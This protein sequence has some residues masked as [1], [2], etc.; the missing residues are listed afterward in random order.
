MTRSPFLSWTILGVALFS[1]CH[2]SRVYAEESVVDGSDI[3]PLIGQISVEGNR[4]SKASS[5]LSKVKARKGDVV[6]DPA[7]RGDVDRLLESGLFEDVEVAVEDLPGGK[8]ARGAAKVRVIFKIKERPILRRIDFKGNRKLSDSKFR[9]G[10]ISKVDEPYDRF[11]ASQDVSKILSVYHDEGYLDAQ[12]ESYTSL[13]P[14]T[15]KVIL[16]FFL[17]DGNRVTVKDVGVEGAHAFSARKVRKILKKTRRKKV[18]KEDTFKE[19]VA[20]LVEA[21]RNKGFLEV[22]VDSSRR[23][24]SPDQDKVTLFL[25]IN[26]GRRYTVGAF[27]FH[28]ATL[29]TDRELRRR[30]PWRP[31]NYTTNQ[32]WMSLCGTYKI[33]MPIKGTCERR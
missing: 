8:D 7:F 13:D 9:D 23:E 19:D 15:N 32:K 6:T 22:S 14:R 21:Y 24:F 28:G 27:T 17:T 31:G 2:M 20:L 4:F 10:L 12:A 29:Y 11:K 25:T 3:P 30:W 5:V 16:T 33:C 1:L 18:F 26:E